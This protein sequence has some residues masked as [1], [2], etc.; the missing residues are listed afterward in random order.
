MYPTIHDNTSDDYKNKFFASEKNT[1]RIVTSL[2]GPYAIPDVLKQCLTKTQRYLLISAPWLSKGFVDFLRNFAPKGI[3]IHLLTRLPNE[4]DRSFDAI[5]SLVNIADSNGW[6]TEAK[7]NP[8]L[9]AK[10]IIVDGTTCVF[11]TLNPTGSGMYYNHECLL[12]LKHPSNVKR[13]S[14]FFFKLWKRAENSNWE[15]VRLFHGYKTTDPQFIH[16]KIA[17][18]IVGFFIENSNNAVQKWRLRKD[19][20]RLG[21]NEDD[22]KRTIEDL[23]RDG[24]LYEPKLDMIKLTEM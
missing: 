6:K 17:E 23:L 19:I 10:F 7:C 1:T 5:E 12:V 14:E 11:S 18:K 3:R 13:L 22:I 15:H 4:R 24:V 9:H 2:D 16:K 20:K 21:F 8:N